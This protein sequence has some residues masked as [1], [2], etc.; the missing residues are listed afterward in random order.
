MTPFSTPDLTRAAAGWSIV[1]R[2]CV[3]FVAPVRDYRGPGSNPQDGLAGRAAGAIWT[4]ET[5]R[6]SASGGSVRD[7]RGAYPGARGASHRA[8]HSTRQPTGHRT[9]RRTRSEHDSRA[10]NGSAST[11][12]GAGSGGPAGRTGAE[13][14]RIRQSVIPLR[15]DDARGRVDDRLGDLHRAGGDTAAGRVAGAAAAR[16]ADHRRGDRLWRVELRRARGDVS[17]DR[18]VVRLPAPRDLA[19]LG[20][21]LRL[22][23]VRGDSDRRDRRRG[24]R[25]RDVRGRAVAGADTRCVSGYD[26]AFAERA[27]RD[28]ALVA[29]GAGDCV[30]RLSD[31]REH[32]WRENRRS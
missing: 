1:L 21:S 30:D 20:I 28:R 31:R 4:G 24:R 23:P 19:A 22:D 9:S 17:R 11:G 18:R 13:P 15:R 26:A 6:C 12:R 10:N 27:D 32:P 16:V 8:N 25:I 29:A 3:S 2:Y 7:W 14:P 5:V